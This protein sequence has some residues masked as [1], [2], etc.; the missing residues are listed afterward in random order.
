MSQASYSPTRDFVLLAEELGASQQAEDAFLNSATCMQ[1]FNSRRI[2]LELISIPSLKT[3]D[4]YLA[5]NLVHRWVLS[6][7]AEGF[8]NYFRVDVG[9]LN[10]YLSGSLV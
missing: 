6:T 5:N 2:F 3:I 10:C 1:S 8:T 7:T 4:R 9:A